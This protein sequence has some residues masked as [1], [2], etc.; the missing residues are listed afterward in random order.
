MTFKKV[1]A[2]LVCGVIGTLSCMSAYAQ[3]AGHTCNGGNMELTD[4]GSYTWH[5]E[6]ECDHC[7]TCIECVDQVEYRNYWAYYECDSCDY[8]VTTITTT[9]VD[10][11]CM[12][13]TC[14]CCD[15]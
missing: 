13:T 6:E 11:T 14:T 4:G 7:N 5:G 2:L 15:Y 3:E 8:A 1:A 10:R 12:C 9:E